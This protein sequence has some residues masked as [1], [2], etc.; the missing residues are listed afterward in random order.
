MISQSGKKTRIPGL[1][2]ACALALLACSLYVRAAAVEPMGYKPYKVKASS[3]FDRLISFQEI[4][5]RPGC[6]VVVQRNGELYFYDT[7]TGRKSLWVALPVSTK[8]ES[9][10]YSIA[11]HPRFTE[12]RRYFVQ[13]SAK[14][15]DDIPGSLNPGKASTYR[16]L[17]QQYLAAPGFEKDS[18]EPP[19]PIM[20]LGDFDGPGHQGMY[21]VFGKDGKLYLAVGDHGSNGRETQSRRSYMGTVLR[22]DVDGASGGRAYGIPSDNP[23]AGD[24]DPLVKKEIWS[25]GFR[26]NFKLFADPVSGDVWVGNVGGW[27]EDQVYRMRRG[28]NFGWPRTEGSL[29]FDDSKSLFQYTAP[30]AACDRSG[31]TPP[32]IILPHPL[33][34]NTN[35]LCVIGPVV[36]RANGASAHY[37]SVFYADNTRRRLF[38]TRFGADGKGVQVEYA[39]PAFN[40]IHMA[41]AG[42]GKILVAPTGGDTFYYL[43][44]P[45]LL[46]GRGPVSLRAPGR[47]AGPLRRDG[48]TYDAGGRRLIRLPFL[49]PMPSIL[50]VH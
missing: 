35:S 28:A 29:C 19:K 30:P 26:N 11:F 17:V 16:Q 18:G 25:Y 47:P 49:T 2:S 6:F 22:I 39:Q 43:D 31:I 15:N 32:D 7:E 13:F 14:A 5:G 46:R 40:I 8:S 24:P 36:Y 50:D 12:N 48:V 34:T 9:G 1:G 38:S 41:E 10:V 27:N 37:G 20:T 4:P 3:A 33:L 45:E 21:S 42:D 23:F 44:T